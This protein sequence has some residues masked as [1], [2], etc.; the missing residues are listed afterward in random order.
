M[1]I[2]VSFSEQC[3]LAFPE[4]DLPPKKGH[5]SHKA[6]EQ[7]SYHEMIQNMTLHGGLDAGLFTL[8]GDVK[9][10]NECTKYCCDD[11]HCDLA[12]MVDDA[13]YSVQCKDDKS[14][15]PVEA[16]LS[17]TKVSLAFISRGNRQPIIGILYPLLTNSYRIMISVVACL[18]LKEYAARN[19]KNVISNFLIESSLETYY[20]T[21]FIFIE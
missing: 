19:K 21:L 9:T 7:C 14:C 15:T 10:M 20:R 6:K 4:S 17:K 3:P 13:C 11:E 18:K 2:V 5:V 8:H 16:S 1:S 12:F